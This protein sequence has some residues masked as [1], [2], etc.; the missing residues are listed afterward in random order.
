MAHSAAKYELIAELMQ[1]IQ[2]H[3]FTRRIRCR[4]FFHDADPLRCGRCTEA[5][6]GR[7]LNMAAVRLSEGELAALVEHYTD[8]SPRAIP[9]ATVNYLA[10]CADVDEVF[11]SEER[12]EEMKSMMM[13]SS[14]HSTIMSTWIPNN[15]EEEEQFMHL[16]HRLAAL[17]KARGVFI[18]NIYTDVDRSIS[19]SPS[20]LNPRRGGKVTKEQFKR[21]WPFKKE[22]SADE[23]ELL[24][25]RFSTQSGDVHFIALHNEVAEVLPDPAQPFPTSPLFLRPDDTQ[26]SHSEASAVDRIRCKVVE[27]RARMREFFQDF[28][29]LR[30]GFCTP[31]QVK[32]VFTIL[33]LSKEIDRHDY[34]SLLTEYMGDDGLFNYEEFCKTVD[35]AFTV[36]GLEKNPLC[37]VDL[38]DA[39]ST[40]AA[41][42]NVMRLSPTKTNKISRVE[43]RIRTFVRKRRSEMKPMFQD[44]DRG[45]R[46]YVTRN[47]FAR[48]MAM[49]NIDLDETAIGLLCGRYC[50]LG[51]HNDFNWR[52]F[53]KTVDP[54][55]EDVQVAMMQMTSPFVA[56][57]P[58]PYFDGHGRVIKR[59]MSTPMIL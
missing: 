47:Q 42:R 34:E 14:P 45:N 20:M 19:P 51:N 18:K 43:D 27:K 23:I 10:F 9:P 29:P 4:E 53:L 31:S 24:C 21:A 35:M 46:G 55:E 12:Q 50:D 32:T 25:Q 41:R 48:I 30:K 22:M 36:P 59:S 7:G 3:A 33:N 54:L 26:W 52:D 49:M 13:T 38:P 16:L 58:K 39:S 6:F 2:M 11:N 8:H 44:F 56:F 5:F 40:F 1:R 57:K 17:C 28:D 15:V 37:V